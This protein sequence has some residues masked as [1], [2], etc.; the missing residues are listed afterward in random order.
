MFDRL[1]HLIKL[2]NIEC[3]CITSQFGVSLFCRSI[4]CSSIYNLAEQISNISGDAITN[5]AIRRKTSF[6]VDVNEG[7]L[8]GNVDFLSIF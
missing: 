8:W 6:V 3:R 2:Q 7:N 5:D 1:Y 4:F